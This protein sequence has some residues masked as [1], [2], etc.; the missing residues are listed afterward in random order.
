MKTLLRNKGKRLEGLQSKRELKKGISWEDQKIKNIPKISH[1]DS[2][3]ESISKAQ[4]AMRRYMLKKKSL[5]SIPSHEGS[6][7]HILHS[8]EKDTITKEMK[9]PNQRGRKEAN[10]WN[11]LPEKNLISLKFLLFSL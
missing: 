8:T 6:F 1:Q 5:A 9:P 11:L 2:Y 10:G 3:N 7:H 4:G